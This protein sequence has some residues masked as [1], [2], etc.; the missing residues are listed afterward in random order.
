MTMTEKRAQAE[1]EQ[2]LLQRQSDDML[3]YVMD[4]ESMVRDYP[5]DDNTEFKQDIEKGNRVLDLLQT[6][7]AKAHQGAWEGLN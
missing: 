1:T 2:D 6:K 5:N 7:I 4:R 3:R